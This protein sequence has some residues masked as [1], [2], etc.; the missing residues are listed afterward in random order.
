MICGPCSL[1]AE[2]DE[3]IFAETIGSVLRDTGKGFAVWV[4]DNHIAL[5]P[6][7][8]L[9]MILSPTSSL[10]T[11]SQRRFS[12][13]NFSS[14]TDTSNVSSDRK[15]Q[16]P[17]G[18]HMTSHPL[19]ETHEAPLRQEQT[20]NKLHQTLPK[21]TPDPP[22]ARE[23]FTPVRGF[24]MLKTRLLRGRISYQQSDIEILY[25]GF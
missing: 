13:G 23:Y 9:Q 18:D 15:V 10:S 25:P 5:E 3:A 14:S 8:L 17:P 2:R 19:L 11:Q 1:P 16:R 7:V 6:E 20:F 22:S 4:K 12:A 21:Q 24:V